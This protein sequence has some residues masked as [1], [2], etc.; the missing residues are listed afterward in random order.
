MHAEPGTVVDASY[1]GQA[2]RFEIQLDQGGRLLV[3]RL[4]LETSADEDRD[5]RGRQVRVA[6][7]EDQT[8][9]VGRVHTPE[10]EDS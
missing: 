1:V 6:W 8:F 2:T 10:Q 9:A 3:T 4:N 7:R 5:L